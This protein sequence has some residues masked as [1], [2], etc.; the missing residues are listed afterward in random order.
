[1]K[2]LVWML[3]FILSLNLLSINLFALY[4]KSLTKKQLGVISVLNL[5]LV[6]FAGL[7]TY[8]HFNSM[9]QNL[10]PLNMI[11]SIELFS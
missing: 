9:I 6:L 2:I 11:K 8:I 7:K 5:I 4:I 3:V 1:M 10:S